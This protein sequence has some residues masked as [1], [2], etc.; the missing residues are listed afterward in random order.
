MY[1]RILFPDITAV[2]SIPGDPP[3][4]SGLTGGLTGGNMNENTR[5]KLRDIELKVSKFADEL[6]SLD[7]HKGVGKKA[8]RVFIEQ[9]IEGYRKVLLEDFYQSNS[10]ETAADNHPVTMDI[11]KTSKPT[12]AVKTSKFFSQ[13]T[14]SESE[15]LSEEISQKGK[16][17]KSSKSRKSLKSESRRSRDAPIYASRSRSYSPSDS[18][19]SELAYVQ[20]HGHSKKPKRSRHDSASPTEDRSSRRHSSGKDKLSSRARKRHSNSNSPTHHARAKSSKKNRRQS[21]DSRSPSP[22]KRSKKSKHH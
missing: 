17:N 2:H 19:S 8:N 4:P 22:H 3:L 1:D 14:D 18:P 9:K 20:E 12:Q 6:E 15:N 7:D 5:R 10:L 11:H 16:K 21:S 13:Y